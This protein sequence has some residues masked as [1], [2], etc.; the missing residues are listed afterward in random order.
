MDWAGGWCWLDR[1]ELEDLANEVLSFGSPDRLPDSGIVGRLKQ[2][3]IA[4]HH[5]S[6]L[7]RLTCH[8]VI[9]VSEIGA[10]HRQLADCFRDRSL[11]V[12]CRSGKTRP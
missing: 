7:G 9:Q 8:L 1:Y 10:E 11:A 4:G 5:N 6:R 12:G 2:E 3:G